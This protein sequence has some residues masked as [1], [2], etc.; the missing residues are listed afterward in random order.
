MT[1]PSAYFAESNPITTRS[2]TSFIQPEFSGPLGERMKIASTQ[3]LENEDGEG[4]DDRE[5]D[6]ANDMSSAFANCSDAFSDTESEAPYSDS[7]SE[8]DSDE[9]EHKFDFKRKISVRDRNLQNGARKGHDASNTKNTDLNA[10]KDSS[11]NTSVKNIKKHEEKTIEIDNGTFEVDFEVEVEGS[12]HNISNPNQINLVTTKNSINDNQEFSKMLPSWQSIDITENSDNFPES[13]EIYDN[14]AIYMIK[15][16]DMNVNNMNV[17]NMMKK[18]NKSPPLSIYTNNSISNNDN[19]QNSLAN[20]GTQTSTRNNTPQYSDNDNSQNNNKNKYNKVNGKE[21][22]SPH[23]PSVNAFFSPPYFSYPPS[24][25]DINKMM[26]VGLK[27]NVFTTDPNSSTDN[28]GNRT[29]DKVSHLVSA[30]GDNEEMNE[31]DSTILDKNEKMMNENER[32]GY[33]SK[34]DDSVDNRSSS[35]IENDHKGDDLDNAKDKKLNQNQN[36]SDQKT[37]VSKDETKERRKS[38]V[39]DTFSAKDER[40]MSGVKQPWIRSCSP[41]A[42]GGRRKSH[43]QILTEVYG[44]VIEKEKDVTRERLRSLTKDQMANE[45]E[46]AINN[47]QKN[48]NNSNSINKNRRFSQS[49]SAAVRNSLLPSPDSLSFNLLNSPTS[50]ASGRFSLLESPTS[51]KK[52]HLNLLDSSSP[53]SA[54]SPAVSVLGSPRSSVGSNLSKVSVSS[55]SHSRGKKKI[56]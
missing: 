42:P 18:G 29:P 7:D 53:K 44:K 50:G 37:K 31:E 1:S 23:S 20:C 25:N 13:V 55:R 4:E 27:D 26:K 2:R 46:K 17:N 8:S 19:N 36:I 39:I 12:N 33:E 49:P 52:L 43:S 38:L 15:D 54:G 24:P 48:S 22:F 41:Y 51:A 10:N 21:L 11:I 14:D 16:D 34:D 6:M 47:I 30:E 32:S 56:Y 9:D 28:D 40:R 3:S 5:I 45:A 35:L